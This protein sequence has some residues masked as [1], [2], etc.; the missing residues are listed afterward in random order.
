VASRSEKQK[1]LLELDLLRALAIIMIVV[2]HTTYYVSTPLL[3]NIITIT[4]PYLVI[5]GLSIF[6]FI[7]GFVLYYND[8]SIRTAADL[9]TFWK[10]RVIRIYPLYWL[11]VVSLFALSAYYV[12]VNFDIS[13][14]ST[15]IQLAGLQSLLAPRFIQPVSIVWFV[16]VILMFYLIYPVIVYP[17]RD[18]AHLI[19][20]SCAVLLPFFLAR[21]A[22]DV[23]D[24]RFF[25]YY[26]IF[27]AGIFTSRF[28]MMHKIRPQRRF[29]CV[30]AVLLVLPLIAI[31]YVLILR[32]AVDAAASGYM[33]NGYG[34]FSY[35]AG[36]LP[37]L[38]SLIVLV[39]VL[40]L[41]FIYV[42]FVAARLYSRSMSKKLLALLSLVAYASYSIYLFHGQIFACTSVLVDHLHLG[43]V[44]ADVALIVLAYPL[45]FGFSYLLRRGENKA[46]TGI[47]RIVKRSA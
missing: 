42:A 33:F 17:A 7:S 26:G 4:F 37:I 1:R 35:T 18:G 24:F 3:H 38:L 43:V 44:Q 47:K 10:K 11:A 28:D 20:T 29:F 14:S 12:G 22:F 32:Q 39:N 19:L 15:V 16:G 2:A 31:R 34:G 41:L 21:L 5:F 23:I 27:V 40:A 13:F 6:F 30:G 9:A 45:I 8:N 46:V 36:E 25:I